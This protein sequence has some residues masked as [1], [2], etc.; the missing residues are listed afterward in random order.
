[1]KDN[2]CTYDHEKLMSEIIPILI[3]R[4]SSSLL[5]ETYLVECSTMMGD[6]LIHPPITHLLFLLFLLFLPQGVMEMFNEK[7][8]STRT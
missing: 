4:I 6:R 3:H 2:S 5:N 7:T 1:M 8:S